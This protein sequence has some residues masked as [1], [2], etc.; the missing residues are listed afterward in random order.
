[1]GR[2]MT[3]SQH[4]S[5]PATLPVC[6]TATPTSF[7]DGE[8]V[9]F[10]DAVVGGGGAEIGAGVV[11]EV[12][13]VVA[14]LPAVEDAFAAQGDDDAVD[15]LFEGVAGDVGLVGGGEL[16]G[17]GFGDGGGGDAQAHHFGEQALGQGGGVVTD[18]ADAVVGGAVKVGRAAGAAAQGLDLEQAVGFEP[19]KVA[20]H[21]G[22]GD[23]QDAAEVGDGGA[24][25]LNDLLQQG[26][27]GFLGAHRKGSHAARRLLG[28]GQFITKSCHLTRNAN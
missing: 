10:A 26:G 7:F 4:W 1:M 15:A 18:A 25:S 3:Y 27:A 11:D 17:E 2:G 23:A 16:A 12:D 5:P 8:A 24:A 28:T 9:G 14:A 6:S 19:I 22:V 20:A 13:A 21:G